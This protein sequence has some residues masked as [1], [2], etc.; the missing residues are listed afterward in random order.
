MIQQVAVVALG[1]AVGASLRFLLSYYIITFEGIRSFSFPTGVLSCNIIGCFLIGIAMA[2]FT[3]N[4]SSILLKALL[5]TGI[6]GGFTTFSSFS[7]DF[8]ALFLDEEYVKAFAYVLITN[9]GGILAAIL[10]YHL[11]RYL[12]AWWAM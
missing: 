8:I 11:Q 9:V 1:G 6:L 5:V 10:G 12:A 2:Y 7:F 3:H 4:E